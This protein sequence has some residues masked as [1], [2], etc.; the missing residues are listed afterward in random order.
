MKLTKN[1]KKTA[2]QPATADKKSPAKLTP[3]R[4][5]AK[6]ASPAPVAAT[7][8]EATT[9]SIASRAYTLWEKD[10]RPA[11]RDVEYWLRAESQIKHSHSFAA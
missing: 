4:V 11:G 10:G 5:E 6:A 9:E 1:V 7:R 3:S 2:S 8:R